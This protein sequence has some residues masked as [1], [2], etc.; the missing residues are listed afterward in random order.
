MDIKEQFKTRLEVKK[1]V[2]AHT[3]ILFR[4]RKGNFQNPFISGTAY[5]YVV[6]GLTDAIWDKLVLQNVD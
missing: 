6:E 4:T 5:K 2:D 3:P 1:F